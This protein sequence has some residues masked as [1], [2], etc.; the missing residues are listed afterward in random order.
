LSAPGIKERLLAFWNEPEHARQ[1]S[2]RYRQVA[3]SR[4]AHL[5]LRNR[6]SVELLDGAI[7]DGRVLDA[8][9]GTGD[10]ARSL[11]SRRLSCLGVDI[12]TAMVAQA[13]ACSDRPRDHFVVGDAE[14]LPVGS[15]VFDAAVCLGVLGYTPDREPVVRELHRALREGG[16][17]IV[18]NQN[19][20]HLGHW[21]SAM[22]RPLRVLVDF[23]RARPAAAHPPLW[24][25]SPRELDAL[26]AR[27]GF[28][29]EAF[30]FLH[31]TPLP[32]P[33]T[34][35]AP[36]TVHRFNMRFER[37]HRRAS[38][39]FLAHGYVARYRKR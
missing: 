7:A 36:A 3:D 1:W 2:Q 26:M 21:V 38:L 20:R 17:A 5:L 33:L 13:R 30:S 22:L 19:K 9:C 31:F 14:R 8:G 29:R 32:Y 15:G 34:A 4:N 16:V 12:S 27:H 28:A 37:F 35:L 10:L 6:R 25:I 11:T 24:L 18:S 23:V 39:R